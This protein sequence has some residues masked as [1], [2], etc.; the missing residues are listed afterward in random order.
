MCVI[1]PQVLHKSAH[2]VRLHENTE[3]LYQPSH[4]T[5]IHEVQAQSTG[6][7]GNRKTKALSAVKLCL[8]KVL[9]TDD[10]AYITTAP[11]IHQDLHCLVLNQADSIYHII[12]I[13]WDRLGIWIPLGIYFK[14]ISHMGCAPIENFEV[15]I[16]IEIS[17]TPVPHSQLS[18]EEYA[19][20][21]LS[22][23]R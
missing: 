14:L 11:V 16:W 17:A 15:Q 2:W 8:N 18:Y 23:R 4:T 13:L 19:D 21:R 1:T 20:R 5:L 3:H 10:A 22:V 6:T 7:A 9:C 12:W